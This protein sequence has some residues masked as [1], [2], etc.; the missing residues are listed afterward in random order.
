VQLP[1]ARHDKGKKTIRICIFFNSELTTPAQKER[2]EML[3]CS[4]AVSGGGDDTLSM[5]FTYSSPN[6]RAGDFLV[7]GAYQAP[8]HGD[9]AILKQAVLTYVEKARS[10]SVHYRNAPMLCII[11]QVPGPWSYTLMEILK[12]GP[13]KILFM[14]EFGHDR[15]FGVPYVKPAQRDPGYWLKVFWNSSAPE[16]AAFKQTCAAYN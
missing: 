7:I 2:K 6:C 5:T 3:G 11:E 12:E 15:K 13:G 1:Y 10:Q 9:V 16:Y 8:T 14:N 4:I